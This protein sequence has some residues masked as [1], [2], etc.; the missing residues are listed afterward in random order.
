MWRILLALGWN[1]ESRIKNTSG[2]GMASLE[3]LTGGQSPL[4]VSLGTTS[5]SHH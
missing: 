1:L 5:A 4:M 2:L 3:P